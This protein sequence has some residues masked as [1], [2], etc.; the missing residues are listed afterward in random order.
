M[1]IMVSDHAFWAPLLF[2]HR[3][4][5]YVCDM[6]ECMPPEQIIIQFNQDG[7]T[8]PSITIAEWCLIKY[9]KVFKIISLQHRYRLTC[10]VIVI[11]VVPVSPVL[12]THCAVMIV[13]EGIAE[14]S[15]S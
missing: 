3:S 9:L 8:L 7:C 10:M 11:F 2:L 5:S 14:L 12:S 15:M 4:K 6:I 13:V 1:L